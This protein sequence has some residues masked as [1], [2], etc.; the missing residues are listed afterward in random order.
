MDITHLSPAA[1][2]QNFAEICAI[3]HASGNEKALSCFLAEKARKMGLLVRQDEFY[4]L[5]IDRPVTVSGAPKILLQGH[6]DMVP[7]AA[8]GKVFDFEKDPIIPVIKGDQIYA[9]GTTLGADD[10]I[11][12]ALAMAVLADENIRGNLSA[13]FTVSEETGL[14]GAGKLA[15]EFLDGD[16]L[17]NLDHG[18]ENKVCIGCAGGIRLA[19]DFDAG[20]QQASA[21]KTVEI[22]LS[23]LPGGHS[24]CC[25][26]EKR[27]NALQ[28]LARLCRGEKLEIASFEGG[29]VDNAIP[30]EAVIRAVL[31]DDTVSENLLLKAQ[32]IKKELDKRFTLSLDIREVPSPDRV[33]S[34]TFQEK[35][36]DIFSTLPN[37]VVEFAPE[38][39]VPRTSSNLASLRCQTGK[40]H[41]VLSARS[42]DDE[43][44]KQHTDHLVELLSVLSPQVTYH[45][46]YP[47]WTPDES[48]PLPEMAVALRKELTGKETEIEVIHAGL[49]AGCFA[50]KNPRLQ[51]LS[52]SPDSFDIHTA[53]EHVSIPS[54]QEFYV[55]ISAFLNKLV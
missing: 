36:L 54:V 29:T 38:Y 8:P 12:V 48:S 46:G 32:E 10:G 13:V 34:R 16:I 21:G 55:F 33:W 5:R 40:L 22:R 4:N 52:M 17:F 39:G 35:F 11:G 30:N 15:P 51:M 44:R 14:I 25:I 9:D 26:H 53:N 47:G 6:L 42:L 20:E 24:G 27:G 19:F 41:L 43:K 1:V 45:S 23:G 18:D 28:M 7:Q 37:G 50:G 2:W 3:P 31:P 49:E